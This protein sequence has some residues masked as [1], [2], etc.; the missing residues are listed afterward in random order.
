ML[1][2]FSKLSITDDAT[3]ERHKTQLPKAWKKALSRPEFEIL[4]T[5]IASEFSQF[6]YWYL[7]FKYQFE[8]KADITCEISF[9]IQEV[10]FE[11]H[12]SD[13]HPSDIIIAFHYFCRLD[14]IQRKEIEQLPL[15]NQQGRYYVLG[16]TS[17]MLAQ[18]MLVDVHD[19]YITDFSCRI[20]LNIFE[21]YHDLLS[22]SDKMKTQDNIL[23]QTIKFIIKQTFSDTLYHR[24]KSID[25]IE[26][27]FK[28]LIALIQELFSQDLSH[29]QPF[30]QELKQE[31]NHDKVVLIVNETISKSKDTLK[32]AFPRATFYIDNNFPSAQDFVD[33]ASKQVSFRDLANPLNT[34]LSTLKKLDQNYH[35]ARFRYKFDLI[36]CNTYLAMQFQN[37]RWRPDIIDFVEDISDSECEYI[38]NARRRS[39][40]PFG[41]YP[42]LSKEQEQKLKECLS[43]KRYS[44]ALF[45][46]FCALTSTPNIIHKISGS[47]F[48]IMLKRTKQSAQE[49]HL[50]KRAIIFGRLSSLE[51]QA[52]KDLQFD[53]NVK[54]DLESCAKVYQ[55]LKDLSSKKSLLQDLTEQS[56]KEEQITSTQTHH[57]D[58]TPP[59]PSMAI[60]PSIHTALGSDVARKN[61][62]ISYQ[63][64]GHE[65]LASLAGL[66][67]A[68]SSSSR[69]EKA[70]TH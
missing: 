18:K 38:L 14:Q 41:S 27:I 29:E 57:V 22:D 3:E 6:I 40:I 64:H 50:S 54:Q 70:L 43:P 9:L 67:H 69:K 37:Q 7:K 21:A 32:E 58:A 49:L 12:P 47:R 16:I 1:E 61:L 5:N 33:F 35:P 24:K 25:A 60:E 45:I 10:F 59:I 39:L 19:P 34:F 53:L 42:G 56:L 52:L 20:D 44:V 26:H 31:E 68:I 66:S 28:E 13:I 65:T 15:E 4:V 11:H 46:C 36:V 51:L 62:L 55:D 2:A 63:Q 17:F 48:D 23:T 30:I 8:L